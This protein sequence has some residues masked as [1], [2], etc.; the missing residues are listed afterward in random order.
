MKKQT[1]S[2]IFS[3]HSA[4][5]SL[6]IVCYLQENLLQLIILYKVNIENDDIAIIIRNLRI[7]TGKK[8]CQIE[9]QRLQKVWIW[10]FGLLAHQINSLGEVLKLKQNFQK[11]TVVP[12]KTLFFVIGPFCT[13]HSIYLNIGFWYG[14]FVWK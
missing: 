7:L 1:S 13:H 6:I 12:G 11:N 10:S 4:H 9:F 5:L 3:L 14:R 8:Y 2:R